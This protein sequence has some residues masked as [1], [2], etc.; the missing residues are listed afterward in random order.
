MAEKLKGKRDSG[1]GRRQPVGV[2]NGVAGGG[3][4]TGIGAPRDRLRSRETVMEDPK[5][6]LN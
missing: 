1:A 2:V 4:G 3:G 5:M 6:H